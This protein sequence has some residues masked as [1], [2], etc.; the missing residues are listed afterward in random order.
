M[1]RVLFILMVGVV[2]SW[3]AR[4]DS[5]YGNWVGRGGITKVVIA[6]NGLTPRVHIYGKCHPSA[7]DWGVVKANAYGPR[8]V[9][10]LNLQTRALVAIYHKSFAQRIVV[11][12]KLGLRRIKVEVFTKF[13]DGSGRSNYVKS[14]ILER[15]LLGEPIQ[16][17][18]PLSPPNHA[19][20]HHYPRRTTL[21]WTPLSNAKYYVVE[22]DCYHCC[23]ANRWCYNVQGKAWQKVKVYSTSYTFNFVGAQPGRWRVWAVYKNG[24]RSAKT[25]WQYFRYT[26]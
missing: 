16:V 14:Y 26:R 5:F 18:R 6:P 25:P 19:V 15:S 7:C 22:I 11:I 24:R 2:V 20:F 13:T 3:A 17:I 1:L 10:N 21:R 9:A 4:L 23:K 12:K 8:V